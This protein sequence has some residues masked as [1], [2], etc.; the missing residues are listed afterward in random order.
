MSL[1]SKENFSFPLFG[2][3][4]VVEKRFLLQVTAAF[5]ASVYSQPA[6]I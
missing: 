6:G 1:D 2:P 3:L 4:A 5:S